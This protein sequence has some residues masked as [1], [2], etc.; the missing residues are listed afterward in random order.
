MNKIIRL[1]K[2]GEGEEILE[3][4]KSGGAFLPYTEVKEINKCIKDN[5]KGKRCLHL[6]TVV[7]KRPIG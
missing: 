6:V 5:E 1:A 7:Y 2:Q 3:V 4:Y